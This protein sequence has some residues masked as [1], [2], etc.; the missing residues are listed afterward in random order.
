MV[1]SGSNFLVGVAIGRFG[2]ATELG[3]YA[4]ALLVWL[5][6]IGIQRAVLSEPLILLEREPADPLKLRRTLGSALAL[7]LVLAAVVGVVG[8]ALLVMGSQG[9]GGPLT[10]FA[11][12]LPALLG[13]DLWRAL[14]F[15]VHRPE[16]ALANDLVF[17]AM[18]VALMLVLVA[19]D[20]TSA[21]WFVL[22]WG[23]GAAAG[24]A[25]G[26]VQFHAL[27]AVRPRVALLRRLWPTSHW[28]LWDFLTM[29]G[30]REM[31]LLVVAAMVTSAEFGGL[32]AAE[33]LLGPSVVILL[34][35]GN[36]GLPGA[37]NAFR[38]GG[39]AALARYVNKLTVGVGVAQWTYSVVVAITGQWLLVTMYGAEFETFGYLV[40]IL[41]LRHAISVVGFGPSIGVKVAG[42]MREIFLA[43]FVVAVISLPTAVV[44]TARYGLDG[45]ATASVALAAVLI[46][47]LYAV[48]LPGL[49]RARPSPHDDEAAAPALLTG[50]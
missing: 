2:G 26:F 43:R 49:G 40:P 44:A 3:G 18:Q 11:L 13:Q 34:S 14:A 39:S 15:G 19:L 32:R 48:Y 21:P 4:V 36:V 25:Y 47:V 35:G 5:A 23:G 41:A 7:A 6:V 30:A 22:A 46:V 24:F 12:V 50:S 20:L 38:A 9:V 45:A 42:L 16:R 29:F 10:V 28:L 1:S 8:V 31:Y 27:P 33:S 37:T 17:T